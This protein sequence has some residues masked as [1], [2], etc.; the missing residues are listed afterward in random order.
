VALPAG[1][2]VQDA[3][4]LLLECPALLQR[5]TAADMWSRERT[6]FTVLGALLRRSPME[7]LAH[8]E[9]VSDR[10]KVVCCVLQG[11]G[12]GEGEGEEK[13]REREGGRRG[14]RGQ[15]AREE[16]RDACIHIHIR[17]HAYTGGGHTGERYRNLDTRDEK[18]HKK[19]TGW[20]HAGERYRNL[21]TRNEVAAAGVGGGDGAHDTYVSDALGS[22]ARG[23]VLSSCVVSGGLCVCVCV[24]VCFHACVRA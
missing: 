3:L 5:I 4:L 19:N 24:C 23:A 1:A 13:E 11:E 2:C 20:G 6:E 22:S 21:D 12:E 14:G 10:I 9:D 15:R 8:W 18:K 17:T 7:D 16:E